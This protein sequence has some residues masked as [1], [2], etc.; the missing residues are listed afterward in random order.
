MTTVDR[1]VDYMNYKYILLQ[2][3]PIQWLAHP[4][5]HIPVNLLHGAPS[6][7]WPGQATHDLFDMNCV[8]GHT[9]I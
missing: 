3:V 9:V 6:L 7:Q 4:S 5:S 2:K 8:S 1:H